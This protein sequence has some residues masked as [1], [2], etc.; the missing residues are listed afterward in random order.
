MASFPVRFWDF[1][2]LISESSVRSSCGGV[3]VNDGQ[4]MQ[5]D[6]LDICVPGSDP[7]LRVLCVEILWFHPCDEE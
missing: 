1:M 3:G 4:D 6:I 5:E 7:E 2:N